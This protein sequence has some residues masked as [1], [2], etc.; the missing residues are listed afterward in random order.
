M[1]VNLARRFDRIKRLLD[2][3]AVAQRDSQTSRL[4][5][6]DIQRELDVTRAAVKALETQP[7]FKSRPTGRRP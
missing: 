5:L 6:S 3:L 7:P 2:E 1:D 4:L